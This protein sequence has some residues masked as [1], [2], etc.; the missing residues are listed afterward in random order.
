MSSLVFLIGIA[1]LGVSVLGAAFVITGSM[2]GQETK[3]TDGETPAMAQPP[4]SYFTEFDTADYL[5]ISFKELDYMRESGILDGSFVGITSL[6]KTGEEEYYDFVDGMEV[7]KTRPVISSITRYIF[8]REL[9]DKKMTDMISGGQAVNTT[10][11]KKKQE[12]PVE[13]APEKKVEKTTG[14][15]PENAEKTDEKTPE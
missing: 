13:K 2:G 6:E 7:I 11:R 5:G 9:L 3:S 12:K 15:A 4:L 8:S 1:I 14:K 10:D